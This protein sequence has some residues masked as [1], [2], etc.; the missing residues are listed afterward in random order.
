MF[1]KKKKKEKKKKDR[2]LIQILFLIITLSVFTFLGECY[3]H[4]TQKKTSGNNWNFQIFSNIINLMLYVPGDRTL[5]VD[6]RH[7]SSVTFVSA[8]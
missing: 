1:K 6:D 4:A 5:L 8:F 2:P 3:Q 7:G